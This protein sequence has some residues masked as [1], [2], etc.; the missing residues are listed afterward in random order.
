[1]KVLGWK[2][3]EPKSVMIWLRYSLLISLRFVNDGDKALVV[4]DE[5]MV[6]VAERN[7]KGIVPLYYEMA[8]AEAEE[9]NYKNIYRSLTLAYK[10]NIGI[11]SNDITKIWNSDNVSL[12]AISW[13][14]LFNNFVIDYA[15][16]LFLPNY[17]D[18]V[19]Q[20][21]HKYT[22]SKLPHFFIYAKDKDEKQVEEVN[23]SV[24]NRLEYIIPNKPIRFKAIAGEFNYNMLMSRENVNLN[25]D[26]INKYLKFHR[27]KKWKMKLQENIKTE[28]ELYIYRQFRDEMLESGHEAEYIT[29]VLVKYLYNQKNSKNKETLWKTFGDVLLAN[30]RENLKNTKQCESCGTRI[31]IVNNQS[32]YCDK[33]FIKHR[34]EYKK[35]KQREYRLKKRGQLNSDLKLI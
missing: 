14:T 29:D 15:K 20:I 33:C 5:T 32:K 9:I 24:V 18:H 30:L 4:A 22:K 16:T 26:I 25:K 8:K 1:V 31:E 11:I 27:T 3:Q 6:S 28:H 2:R 10:A 34:K 17:P 13:L 23:D 7:M 35:E 12:K 21:I 19:K